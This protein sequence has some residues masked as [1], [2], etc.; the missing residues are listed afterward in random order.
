MHHKRKNIDM[1]KNIAILVI[2]VLFF[3]C[4]KNEETD[5]IE[6]VE[7]QIW[8]ESIQQPCDDNTICKL[9]INQ[10]IYNSDTVYFD[11]YTGPLCDIVFN[12]SLRNYEG[13]TIKTYF[14][15]NG[16]DDFYEEVSEIEN[17]YRCDE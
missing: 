5:K 9:L 2:G 7:K 17:I 13:D 14:G 16:Y 4:E 15:P 3:S 10:G 6:K 8:Y 11:T 12:V 1:K